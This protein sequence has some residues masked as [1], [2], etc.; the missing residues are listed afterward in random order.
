MKRM[1]VTLAA[2]ALLLGSTACS[3]DEAG[4]TAGEVADDVEDAAKDAA[5]EA[6]DAADRAEDVLNDESVDIDNFAYEPKTVTVTRGTEVTW[7]NRDDAPH[8]VTSDEGDALDSDELGEG[9]EF[10]ERFL[11]DGTFEYHC[12][13]HGKDRMSGKVVVEQ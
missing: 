10:S 3:A 1:F 2:L 5:D 11:E 12:E 8:T 6:R 7:V 9:D 13:V 4:D